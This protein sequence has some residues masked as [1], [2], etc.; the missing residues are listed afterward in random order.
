M[1]K[2]FE[3]VFKQFGHGGSMWGLR[4]IPVFHLGVW[5]S[6]IWWVKDS[7]VTSPHRHWSPMGFPEQKYRTHVSTFSGLEEESALCDLS[8]EERA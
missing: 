6:G 7:Y 8:W 5:N 2:L 4:G 3:F 1:T